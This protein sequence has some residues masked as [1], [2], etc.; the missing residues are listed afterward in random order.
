MDSTTGR[1]HGRFYTHG[2]DLTK[3]AGTGKIT[4]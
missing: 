1:V 4:M 3:W 2:G